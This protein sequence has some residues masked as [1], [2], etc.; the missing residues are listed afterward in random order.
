MK[1]RRQVLYAGVGCALAVV[2]AAV[3]YYVSLPSAVVGEL[4]RVEFPIRGIDVSSHNGTIDFRAVKE[5]GIDFVIIKATEGNGFKDP[6]F[7]YNVREAR[8][9]GLKVGAYH[10]FRFDAD[11]VTQ[12]INFMH[13]IRGRKLDL[14]A[15]VDL[16]EWTNPSAVP[17]D[18]V[19]SRLDGMLR[20]LVEN[21][22][23]VLIYTNKDGYDR[24][25][26]KRFGDYPLWL[27]SF[28]RIDTPI[29]W[30]I[31]QYSHCGIVDGVKGRVD[32]NV[33][34]GDSVQWNEMCLKWLSDTQ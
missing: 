30:T 31:W 16:E 22:Y 26:E 27:C 9:A 12:A 14:P 4:S 2:L 25:V 1:I 33:F 3:V 17:D 34:R 18:T 6:R 7:A 15:V 29:D 24:F 13:S 21:G 8:R 32:L 20:H 19:A 5:S 28:S 10:F 23:K 11:G